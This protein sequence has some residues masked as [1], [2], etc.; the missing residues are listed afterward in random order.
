[1]SNN[2]RLKYAEYFPGCHENIAIQRLNRPGLIG[3]CA[4]VLSRPLLFV[5]LQIR[6]MRQPTDRPTDSSGRS[7]SMPK[8]RRD[9]LVLK[10][11]NGP[12]GR[13][14]VGS[15]NRRGNA[16]KAPQTLHFTE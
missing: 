16:E 3:G 8:A 1:L 9:G 7:F 12:P 4:Q 6:R 14:G 11:E 13:A 10:I 2:L 15:E 5:Q